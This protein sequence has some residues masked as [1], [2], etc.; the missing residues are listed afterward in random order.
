MLISFLTE[1][2]YVDIVSY[3]STLC[4]YR[5]SLK[6]I[7]SISFLTEAHYVDIVSYWS[8]LCWY[9]FLL[10]HANLLSFLTKAQYFAVAS[11]WSTSYCYRFSQKL[12]ILLSLLTE[13][14]YIF[15]YRFSLKLNTALVR[16]DIKVVCFSKKRYQHQDRNYHW[17]RRGNCLV[18]FPG[19]RRDTMTV[20]TFF[21]WG[22][23]SGTLSRVWFR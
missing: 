1:A 19:K 6:H 18:G 10:N 12:N 20:L 3:W 15:C 22:G 16:N 9:R 7:M 5:F 2:H 8:T 23:D 21:F 17:G 14:R 4:W 13:A 11:H